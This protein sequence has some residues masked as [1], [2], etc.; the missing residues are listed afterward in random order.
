MKLKF[1]QAT[2]AGLI[3]SVSNI[4]SATLIEVGGS[5]VTNPDFVF[6]FEMDSLS[7]GTWEPLTNQFASQGLSVVNNAGYANLSNG[8]CM[9]SNF[10]E[11]DTGYLMIGVSGACSVSN[12]IDDVTFNF[13]NF[14]NAMSFDL[15]TH[16]TGHQFEIFL[17]N[18]VAQV[19]YQQFNGTSGVTEVFSATGAVFNSF[20]IREFG[21]TGE[22]LWLDQLAVKYEPTQEVPEPSTLAIFALGMIGLASRRFK[23]QS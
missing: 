2:L 17:Y 14:V 21:S 13:S 7:N 18:D 15:Y 5:E 6:G 10:N 4:A 11:T 1:L 9:P 20:Q 12:T 3:L 19:G 23:K 22:W 8:Y 16:N